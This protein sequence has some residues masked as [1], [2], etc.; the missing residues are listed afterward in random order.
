MSSKLTRCA[1]V[2]FFLIPD[3]CVLI[4]CSFILEPCSLRLVP[5]F[6]CELCGPERSGREKKAFVSRQGAKGAK[7]TISPVPGS[8]FRVDWQMA[9]RNKFLILHPQ[10]FVSFYSVNSQPGTRNPEQ[11]VCLYSVNPQLAT[12]NSF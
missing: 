9:T 11:S 3:S 4:P 10:Q 6:P 5:A 2:P 1:F 8:K 7:K 12:R